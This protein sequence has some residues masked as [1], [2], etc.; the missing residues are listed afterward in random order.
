MGRW[1][2]PVTGSGSITAAWPS[3][4]DVAER[5]GDLEQAAELSRKPNV[6]LGPQAYRAGELERRGEAERSGVLAR[7]ERV[8]QGNQALRQER[9]GG[10]IERIK[11][12]IAGI[13]QELQALPEK[14]REAGERVKAWEKEKIREAGLASQGV[15]KGVG[16]GSG[17]M[18]GGYERARD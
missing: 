7:A 3:G 5:A 15:G 4:G 13:Y 9:D 2:G 16:I 10:I 6:H 14:I 8:E 12:R 11:E 1:S 17:S 18:E